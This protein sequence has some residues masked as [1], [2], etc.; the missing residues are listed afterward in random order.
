MYYKVIK[1]VF[2]QKEIVCEVLNKLGSKIYF[3]KLLN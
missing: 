3:I 2:C 1:K